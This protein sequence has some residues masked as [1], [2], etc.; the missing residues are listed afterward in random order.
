MPDDLLFQTVFELCV[1]LPGAVLTSL[2]ALL[3][4][5]RVRLERPAVGVFN[6][7][8][9][10][11]LVVFLAT[12]PLIYLGLPRWAVTCLLAVTFTASLSIGYRPLLSPGR[13]WLGIGLLLGVNI[14]L[15]RTALGTVLGW[16]LFWAEGN[17]IMLLG[18]VSVANLYVQ[19]RWS[20]TSS[21]SRSTRRWACGSGSTT[22]PSASATC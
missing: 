13:L 2:C 17:I 5:R 1:A 4:L 21:A 11:V 22:P 3:Y 19:T 15:G 20:R 10:A 8:D 18:A 9:I 7:R 14:W 6:G 16:Q 12:L